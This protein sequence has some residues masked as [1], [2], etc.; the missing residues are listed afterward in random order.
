M[1]SPMFDQAEE[2]HNPGL[3]PPPTVQVGPLS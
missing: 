1:P 3:L 2:R